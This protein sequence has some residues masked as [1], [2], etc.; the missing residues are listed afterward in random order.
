MEPTRLHC[1]LVLPEGPSRRVG[2][3]GVW[4]G[5]Q[6]D[7]DLVTQDPAASR[8]HAL[9][10][11]T[12]E[13][14]ELVPLGREPSTRNGRAVERPV[15]LTDGDQIGVPGLNMLVRI[16]AAAPVV[17]GPSG[18]VLARA[19]GGSFGVS[20]TP[21]V[22]GGAPSADLIMKDW[23]RE[24]ILRVHVAQGD[25][26]VELCSG[27]AQLDVVALEPGALEPLPLGA[28]IACRGELFTVEVTRGAAVTTAVGA[29]HELPTRIEIEM[30]PRGGRVAFTLGSGERRVYLADR[31]LDLIMALLRPP[32]GH[33]AGELVPDDVVRSVVWPRNAGVGRVELNTL[34]ARC[35]RDLVDAGLAGPLLI[36]RAPG[37]SGTRFMLAPNAEI[38]VKS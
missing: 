18:F 11:L 8:R 32:A 10:R 12:S 36:V 28:R 17:N 22:I 25:A 20:H 14:V 21:F 29:R 37:G 35:R 5:R 24:P 15:G 3:A 26:F 2:G 30:L 9:V 16:E 34:I 6:G 31:R 1:L 13:G 23:P 19:K 27:D 33:Q 38:V 4:I 7:C